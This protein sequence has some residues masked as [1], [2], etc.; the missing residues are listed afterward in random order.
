M[1][2]LWELYY[3]WFK[4]GLFTF[5]G[6]YAMLPMIQRE[7]IDK[8][9]WCSEEEIMDYY[10]IGQVT[11]GIIAV[12]TA[13]FVGYDVMGIPGGIISTLGVISPS[14]VIITIIAGLITNFS[15]LAVVQSALRGIQVA[16]CALMFTAV[17]KLYKSSVKDTVTF[18]IFA[19]AL[20]L[21]YFTKISTVILV[22]AAGAVGY[23]L[24]IMRKEKA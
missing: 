16:V 18:V 17:V 8:H 13:T 22:I 21:A 3:T 2:T 6:G 5:G 1:K 12:N 23:A 24:S 9:H 11:P 19:V 7:V 15:E 14:I 20:V 4:M 10:A